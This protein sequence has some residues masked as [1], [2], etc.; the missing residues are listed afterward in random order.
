MIWELFYDFVL[1]MLTGTNAISEFATL[2]ADLFATLITLMVL[3]FLIVFPIQLVIRGFIKWL[4]VIT[5]TPT[6]FSFRRK[7]N[8]APKFGKSN[9][10]EM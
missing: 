8:K 3:Y 2:I 7:F 9:Q 1:A 6:Y 4:S 10:D 5:G